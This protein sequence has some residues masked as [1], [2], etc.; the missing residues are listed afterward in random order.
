[1]EINRLFIILLLVA[2]K[3]NSFAQS[4]EAIALAE[5]GEAYY[6]NKE[7]QLAAETYEKAL[8]TNEFKFGQ[9]YYNTACSWALAGD[10]ENAFRNL[11]S[12]L[13]YD[14]NDVKLTET[15][16]DLESLRTDERWNVLINKFRKKIEDRRAEKLKELP[17][18][19]WGMYLGI[20]L[21][22]FMYNLMM[23]FSIRDVTYLY[24]S[25]S[26]FFLSQVHT[27]IMPEFGFY[28]KEFFFWLKAYPPG[29]TLS[30]PLASVV[31][32]FHLL[33]IRGFINL[34]ER[35]PK[36][37][38]YNNYMIWTLLIVSVL[39]IFAKQSAYVYFPMFMIAYLLSLYI[40]IYSWMKGFK[41]ARFLV[42]GSIFLTVG[43]GIVLLNGLNI[44]DL[45]FN[46]LGLHTDNL[47]FI[48]FYAFLSFALGD[49]INVL[50]REKAEAQEK[51]L[52]VLEAKVQERTAE[53]AHEKQ[54]VEEKQKD[55]LD[56]IR[57]AKRIQTSLMPNEKYL[58][59][60]FNRRKK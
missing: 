36:L 14:W 32:V 59:G 34:K 58:T 57:Y 40:S 15:D 35:H 51:A 4:K 53:L 45:R 28:A 22:F 46:V 24:Y 5:K 10:K 2:L 7:Y 1:M 31:I 60:I 29:K 50:T 33:F 42:T 26:I 27:I 18:Y 23:F 47:G 41:P 16:P 11:D 20:L 37:N 56:S 43:V 21:I 30:Y 39:L 54:L 13:K 38:K 8:A 3:A 19:Y 9:A 48:C 44:V 6:K 55:I 25:L 17:T 12:S 52:E 49:K